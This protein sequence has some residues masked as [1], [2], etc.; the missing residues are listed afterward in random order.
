MILKYWNDE[1]NTKNV[2]KFWH[3]SQNFDLV[4]Q[5]LTLKSKIVDQK[6]WESKFR[7]Q[8][9]QNF[10]LKTEI[11]NLKTIFDLEIQKCWSKI[12]NIDPKIKFWPW[13]P[14]FLTKNPKFWT[15]K[16]K[17]WQ[18]K[19]KFRPKRPNCDPRNQIS[20]SK[21]SK[22]DTK[23]KKK[24]QSDWVFHWLPNK[25]CDRSENW[26]KVGNWRTTAP[27]S[28]CGYASRP[29]F[30]LFDGH[31]HKQHKHTLTAVIIIF[32]FIFF[33]QESK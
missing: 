15:Q 29:F 2:D 5:S 8:K 27:L 11:L 16:P 32:F 25:F 19:H 20:T 3:K 26:K 7:P 13:N 21:N 10:D 33:F 28:G 23:K 6:S 30:F 22:F 18:K 31:S 24:R 14:K 1:L 4:T 12:Q 9:T 17:C